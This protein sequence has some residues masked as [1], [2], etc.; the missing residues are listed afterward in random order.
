[1]VVAP[2]DRPLGVGLVGCGVIGQI[3]ADTLRLL[4]EDG[5]MT[6]VAA[7]DPVR[8]SQEAARRNCPFRYTTDDAQA[9]IADPDVEAVLVATPTDTHAAL[10]RSALA[11]GKPVLCEKPLAPSFAEVAHLV[12]D[13]ESAGTTAQVGFHQRFHPIV[14]QLQETIASGDLGRVMGYTL[15][16]DQF[17]PTGDVMPGHSSWRSDRSHAG[18]GALIEHSIHAADILCLLFGVPTRVF[19]TTRAFF[20]YDVE[21]VAALTLEHPSGVVGTL[22]SVFNGVRGREE[23]RFEVFF[24]QATVETTNDFI[25][26]ADED[27]YFVARAGDPPRRLDLEEMRKAY[28]DAQ[29]VARRD[30]L[31][32][33]Y[34]ADRAWLRAA[35][36][37]TAASPGFGDALAAHAVVE[38]AYRSAARG[39][40]VEVAEVMGVPGS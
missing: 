17:W 26:G 9:L 20:G 35:R 25:V 21:D 22:I 29:G 16:E 19:A 34:L 2:T 40:P 37:G 39:A 14:A 30:F 8:G 12:A 7:A 28:F 24:E 33:T 6:P 23:R 15:R 36:S 4:V 1:M 32:Y 11:L 5:E 27:S 31:F 3:H 18:G 13:V 38:A 10:V